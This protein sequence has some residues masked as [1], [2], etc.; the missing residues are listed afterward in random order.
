MH[1]KDWRSIQIILSDAN[2]PGE[3]EH[4]IINF[5]RHQQN[6]ARSRVHVI[7]S[8]DS[9]LVLLGLLTHEPEIMILCESCANCKKISYHAKDCKA[10]ANCKRMGHDVK[11]CKACV[12]CKKIG[13]HAKDCDANKSLSTKANNT[14]MNY[15]VIRLSKL[16]D[17][18]KS[19]K[20]DASLFQRNLERFIDD[21]VLIC[22][23]FGNDFLPKSQFIDFDKSTITMDR[24]MDAYRE[25]LT[26]TKDYL[27]KN[28]TITKD[29]LLTLM[30]K[31]SKKDID[32]KYH[33]PSYYKDK[34]RRPPY[35]RDKFHFNGTDLNIFSNKVA[36]DYVQGLCW[37]FQYYSKGPPS[38]N[39]Y[40]PHHYAP[41]AYD[42]VSLKN[43]DLN[44]DPPGKPF[45]PFEQMMATFA[46]K[47]AE[48]VPSAWRSLMMDE[49]FGINEFYPTKFDIDQIGTEKSSQPVAIIPFIDEKTLFA[50]LDSVPLELT[51]AEEKCNRLDYD[52]L[53]IHS[54]HSIYQQFRKSNDANE[55]PI[56]EE[57]PVQLQEILSSKLVEH[58][59]ADDTDDMNIL[60][61]DE[62]TIVSDYMNIPND[63]VI[64]LKHCICSFRNET[65]ENE[66]HNNVRF[67]TTTNQPSQRSTVQPQQQA[68][69]YA[70]WGQSSS[71]HQN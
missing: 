45:R 2:V 38:W 54:T 48:Y 58:V 71:T 44:F 29:C 12:N 56:T 46:P 18:F 19:Q 49:R 51:E 43:L 21:W 53:F 28:G 67:R 39:W 41:L 70:A 37:I 14:E 11:V 33:R 20:Y 52:C 34:F 24:L 68:S 65:A 8:P 57:N 22:L 50:A 55:K 61:A 59:W 36:T 66:K 40:Y 15:A 47:N 27:T 9:D 42:F 16:I 26:K 30:E 69:K 10:C 5:I 13:Y 31:V 63:Q 62:K 3:G 60:D 64:L 35:Y 1:T 25:A 6:N 4:K 7:Y 23:L 32:G 17:N